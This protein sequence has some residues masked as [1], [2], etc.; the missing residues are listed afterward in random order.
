MGDQPPL[1]PGEIR[2]EA[3]NQQPPSSQEDRERRKSPAR[4]IVFVLFVAVIITSIKFF[5]YLDE[6]H[7]LQVPAQP[8]PPGKY[9]RFDVSA[10]VNGG[11]TYNVVFAYE[12]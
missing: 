9:A 4:L 6:R 8:T 7:K 5:S 12:P 3:E 2:F 10:P 11:R 1:K